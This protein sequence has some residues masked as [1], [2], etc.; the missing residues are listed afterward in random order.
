VGVVL[1][2]RHWYGAGSLN[3]DELWI[4]LN[5]R[6]RSFAGLVGPLDYDQLA[7]LGWLWLEKLL[8]GLGEGDRLLRLPSL[9]AGCAVLALTAVLARRL[10]SAPLAVAATALLAGAPQLIYQS[11]QVKQYSLEAAACVLLLVLAL[12]AAPAPDTGDSRRAVPAFWLAG[13]VAVWF[14]TTAAFATVSAGAALVLFAVWDRRWLLIRRHALAALPAMASVGVAY[15]V[16][17]RPA[18]WLYRWW[19]R[20][21][22]G[23]LAPEELSPGAVL[24]WSGDLADR[25]AASALHVESRSARFAVLSLI[26]V[27]AVALAVRAPRRATLVCAPLLTAY[28]LA[29]LRLYPMATRVALWLV[30]AALVLLCA[31]VD[32]VARAGCAALSRWSTHGAAT[33]AGRARWLAGAEPGGAALRRLAGAA[34]WLPVAGAAALVAGSTPWWGA[35]PRGT[36]ADRYVVAEEA[37]EYVVAHRR[38]GDRVLA[39][40]GVATTAL[41]HWYGPRVG[42]RPDGYYSTAIDRRCRGAPLPGTS[43][44]GVWLLRI[45]WDGPAKASR[46]AER[47]AM[48]RYGRLSSERWLGKVVILRYEPYQSGAGPSAPRLTAPSQAASG[49]ASAPGAPCL[50][51]VRPR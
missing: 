41:T 26:V 51:P 18:G 27:G 35:L 33:G 31:A 15:L 14:A 16:A 28:L 50:L 1:R 38:P 20:T 47:G 9:V 12:R 44:G 40:G 3:S 49:R 37:L 22:P 5:L 10:L 13:G 36:N 8:L 6:R 24:S 39:H 7:P 48:A 30:P 2:V 43:S 19:E 21:Y 17:P 42:L 4:A 34:G 45:T 25:F 29:L 11:A 23:S 32:G 46:Y